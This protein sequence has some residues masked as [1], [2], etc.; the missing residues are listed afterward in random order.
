MKKVSFL[1]FLV[2]LSGFAQEINS[3]EI[4]LKNGAI[5][6]PGTLSYPNTSEPK[7]LAIFIHGSGNVDRN[8]NQGNLA[9][10]NYI[11]VLADSLNHRGIA[12]YRYDKRTA[13]PINLPKLKDIRFHDLPEDAKLAILHFKKDKRFSGIHL[14]GHSQGSLVGMLL[15][16]EEGVKSYTSLAGPGE[17][18]GI[19]LVKQIKTQNEDLGQASELHIKELME[20]DT[21]QEVNPFLLSIFAPMNQAFLKDWI[22]LD[23]A[24]EIK[25]VTVPTLLLNGDA[26]TQVSVADAKLLL[27]AKPD[28]KLT[29]I[30]KMNHVLKTVENFAENQKSYVDPSF[31]ISGQLIMVIADFI[32]TN[33]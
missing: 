29:I 9:Q 24:V 14:I 21:I 5:E 32:K 19:T 1:W 6:L 22:Q 33:E 15:A 31:S 4:T 11:K 25:K 7:P 26:D 3:E 30:K 20:T 13:H 12:F 27:K 23:P 18:I 17:N 8:G 28:A 16:N 10:A 2:C